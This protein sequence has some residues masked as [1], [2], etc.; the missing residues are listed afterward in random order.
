M[1]RSTKGVDKAKDIHYFMLIL[2][3]NGKNGIV[4]LSLKHDWAT[5]Q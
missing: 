4:G 5:I 3:L 2:P 1:Y